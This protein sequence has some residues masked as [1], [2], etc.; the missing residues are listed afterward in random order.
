MVEQFSEKC[1]LFF[2]VSKGFG[3]AFTSKSLLAQYRP[4]WYHV[5][6]F[7]ELGLVNFAN[8]SFGAV[9]CQFVV[10]PVSSRLDAVA[11]NSQVSN[12]VIAFMKFLLGRLWRLAHALAFCPATHPRHRRACPCIVA[13]RRVGKMR[14]TWPCHRRSRR[15]APLSAGR[16]GEATHTLVRRTRSVSVARTTQHGC[17]CRVRDSCF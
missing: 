13:A 7:K 15:V 8:G 17:P 3:A 4:V 14:T 1:C 16:V 12:L 2:V 5:T 9:F 6:D 11:R 10:R